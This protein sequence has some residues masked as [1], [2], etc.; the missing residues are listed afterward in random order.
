MAD[1]TEA[2]QARADA[3]YWWH[4]IDF[5]NGVVSKGEQSLERM[6]YKADTV[7]SRLDLNAKSVLGML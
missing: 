5:G 6:R 4:T 7:F 1:S 3:Y 2:L